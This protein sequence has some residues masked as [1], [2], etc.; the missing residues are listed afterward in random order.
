MLRVQIIILFFLGR[1]LTGSG[2]A[3]NR[4]D[5][6]IDLFLAG[7]EP[8]GVVV[9]ALSVIEVLIGSELYGD[10]ILSIIIEAVGD[11]HAAGLTDFGQLAC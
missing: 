4:C 8:E 3:F 5:S 7:D 2:N 9:L 10:L 6:G 1:H 11:L